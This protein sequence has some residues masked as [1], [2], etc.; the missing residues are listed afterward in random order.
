M[1]RRVD[2]W[3]FRL[4]QEEK[5][6]S[7]AFFVT[8]TYDPSSV[9]LTARGWMTLDKSHVQRFFKR[10]RKSATMPIKYYV[11]G[12]YGTKRY[13]PHYHAIIFG[14]TDMKH[15]VDAWTLDGKQIGDVHVG[16]VTGDSIAYTIGYIHK[17]VFRRFHKGDDRLP[18]FSL[19]SKGMGANYLTDR[20]KRYHKADVS[21]LYCTKPGGHKIA[22]P[23]YYRDRIFN[24]EEREEQVSL[25]LDTVSNTRDKQLLEFQRLKYDVSYTFDNWLQDQ[26][27]GRANNFFNRLKNSKRD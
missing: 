6:H 15:I 2:G 13:R 25:A 1:K 4:M 26:K 12:E 5:N 23:R 14:A 22:M 7:T 19:M 18:E 24:E 11:A 3:V 27:I 9:P 21:R 8:L 16:R 20:I 17:S 10:L